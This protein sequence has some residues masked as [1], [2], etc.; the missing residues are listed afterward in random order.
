[1]KQLT[2]IILPSNLG[3]LGRNAFYGCSNLKT[4][5]LPKNINFEQSFLDC[6][7]FFSCSSLEA[8]HVEDGNVNMK[9]EDGCLIIIV[10]D[11]KSLAAVPCARKEFVIPTDIE[12]TLCYTFPED[13]KIETLTI[14][15]ESLQLESYYFDKFIYLKNFIVNNTH[16]LYTSVEGVLYSKNKKTIVCYPSGRESTSYA[17][18]EGVTWIGDGCFNTSIYLETMNLPEGIEIIGGNSFSNCKK[19]KEITLPSTLKEIGHYAFQHC[20]NLK[21]IICKATTPPVIPNESY[22]FLMDELENTELYVPAESLESYKST[23]YWK[24]FGDNIKIIEN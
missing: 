22:V 18:N 23:D 9:S 2:E 10:N 16:Q 3:Y 17:I 8:I 13:C 24:D 21:K 1:M 15:N 6:F 5:T 12:Q 14:L 19:L 20:Y 4:I 11:L 7:S